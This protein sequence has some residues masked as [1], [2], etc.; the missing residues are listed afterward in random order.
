MKLTGPLSAPFGGG[1]MPF[2][3][4]STWAARG[5]GSSVGALKLISDVGDTSAGGTLMRWN[6]TYW[7]VLAP[8]YAIHDPTPGANGD[9]T[10]NDQIVKASPA[11]PIGL[12]RA[13]R[14]FIIRATFGKGGIVDATS[15]VRARLGPTG[16]VADPF[17]WENTPGMGT[18]NRNWPAETTHI[19][20][21][22]TNVRQVGPL[23]LSGWVGGG[24]SFSSPQD[25]TVADVDATALI[26]SLS[27]DVNGTTDAP[28]GLYLALLLMP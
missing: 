24:N 27:V 14:E 2:D 4:A 13:C 23:N 8:T 10:G 5:V 18:G 17:L 7:R 19:L 1:G 16:T 6:G 25:K 20:T 12:L 26:L 28:Q 3:G 11:M 9:L 21:S 22:A 15:A